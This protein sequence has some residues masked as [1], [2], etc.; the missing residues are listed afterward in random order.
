VDVTYINGT[1]WAEETVQCR[2][3]DNPIPVK[4]EDYTLD[5]VL[6]RDRA[7]QIGMRRLM[8]YQQQRLT[9]TT[10]TELDALCYNVGDRIVLTDDI[11]G[12]QTVSTLIE[13]M[14]SVDGTTTFTVTELLDWSF[15]N[16]RVLIRYQDGSA[17]SLMV[18]TS[19]GDYRVS[20]PY[21]ATFDDMILDDPG[22]EPPRL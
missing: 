3:P 1:T 7:Y 17:S 19:A 11:P 14:A 15:P 22:I 12:S 21:L 5:G 6:D 2:T 10:S 18:A 8:K 4:I 9:H 16:P 13:S 20:V